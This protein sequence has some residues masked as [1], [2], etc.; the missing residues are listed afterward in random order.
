MHKKH[1]QTYI[2]VAVM[3][4]MLPSA[5]DWAQ[6]SLTQIALPNEAKV[7]EIGERIAVNG[8]PLQLQ[9]FVSARKPEQVAFWFRQTLGKP[10]VENKLGDSL[11][12]G[13]A[14]GERYLT[15][16][17]EPAGTGTRGLITINDLEKGYKRHS[18]TDTILEHWLSHLPTGSRS[19]G[20]MTS[21]DNGKIEEY[22]IF[23]NGQGIDINVD[24]LMKLMG[25]DGYLLQH[26]VTV[27]GKRHFR[28][29]SESN[30]GKFLLFRRSGREAIAIIFQNKSV[31][32]AIVISAI[33]FKE[34]SK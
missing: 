6:P 33:T 16:Q 7:F 21:E 20:R 14:Q 5:L 22:L 31:G 26:Q 9:G 28:S 4:L 13:R 29:D 12:L 15:V 2:G 3:T 30:S 19:I 17:L 27:E 11:V 24:R 32:T 8:I 18:E 1:R 34:R 10:L 25:N 23:S